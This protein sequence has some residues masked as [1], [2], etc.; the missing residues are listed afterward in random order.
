MPD[1]VPIEVIDLGEKE[2]KIKHVV[3]RQAS[4]SDLT[5]AIKMLRDQANYFSTQAEKFKNNPELVKVF[6]SQAVKYDQFAIEREKELETIPEPAPIP[7]PVD[8]KDLLLDTL[9][10]PKEK[11]HRPGSKAAM[12]E[13]AKI[14]AVEPRSLIFAEAAK[15]KIDELERLINT[16]SSVPNSKS[17]IDAY[18]TN[19]E[20][21]K[22][23]YENAIK[24][25]TLG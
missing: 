7:A 15:V 10:P 21:F 11:K 22:T 13:F 12:K 16:Y 24:I 17:L 18:R 8:L 2:K 9:L 1:I 5:A 23:Q 19:L 6:Q 4:R 20:K 14:L 3:P 25:G